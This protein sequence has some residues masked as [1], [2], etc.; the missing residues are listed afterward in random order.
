M[1][2]QMR[3]YPHWFI[4]MLA[5]ALAAAY[6][7]FWA[8][9][10]YISETNVVLNS[11]QIAPPTLNFQSLLSG[12]NGNNADMLLLRDYMLSVDMLR[13]L[14]MQLGF[15]QH[16]A[17]PGIDLLSALESTTVPTEDLHQYYLKRVSVE[18]DDY[19]GVLRIRVQ[20]FSPTMAQE[21]AKLL[22]TE[23]ERRMN[24]MGQ[25]LAEEQVR[26]LE[27]QVNALA[28][29]LD[30]ARRHLIEYQNANGL[31][32]PSGTVASINAV[33]ASLESQKANLRA[34]R[35]AL[36]SYQSNNSIEVRRGDAEIEA[37][38]EQITI[39]RNRMTTQSGGALNVVTSEY[40]TLELRMQFAQESYSGALAAL[41]NT[42]IGAARKLKQLSVLQSP[43]LPEYA[44]EPRR[45]YNIAVFI[46]IALFLTMIVHM[47]VLI[48]QDHRD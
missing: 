2:L 48:I 40:Q 22:L 34:K 36:L 7:S 14:D 31:V 44:V 11:P 27:K 23:G 19:A 3:R 43:T 8:S 29:A 10:R 47:L 16:F 38:T 21:M 18:L 17:D 39:E 35:N 20:A 33:V 15:R 25:R 5:I 46:L 6:W 1:K 42:R 30:L 12:S 41:E 37:L 32:S 28:D 13:K 45:L 4:C 24:A 9:D 26:F